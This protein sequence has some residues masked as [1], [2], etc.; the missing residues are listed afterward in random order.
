MPDVSSL[1]EWG[2][3]A[4]RQA[5]IPISNYVFVYP[6]V[7]RRKD[8]LAVTVRRQY[9][10]FVIVFSET[11]LR[12]CGADESKWKNLVLHE[13]CHTI[14]GCYNHRWKWK[15]MVRRLNWAGYWVD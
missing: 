13:L 12:E 11:A 6:G 7:C 15:W 2:I 5:G 4:C 10:R 14:R 8:F 3:G 1:L 9:N